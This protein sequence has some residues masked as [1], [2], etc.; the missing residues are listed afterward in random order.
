MRIRISAAATL[1]AIVLAPSL[2]RAAPSG[3]VLEQ[4]ADHSV[5]RGEPALLPVVIGDEH[6]AVELQVEIDGELRASFLPWS[7][8]QVIELDPGLH[9]VSVVGRDPSTGK[10]LRSQTVQVAV[11]GEPEAA[12]PDPRRRNGVTAVFA[13]LVAI[14]G[15]STLRRRSQR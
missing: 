1:L 13:F 2:A 12:R 10:S 11:F 15:A 6:A 7:H 4:P 5:L 3:I 9:L 14:V 8:R